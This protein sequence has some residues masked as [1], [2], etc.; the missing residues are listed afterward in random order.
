MQCICCFNYY[1]KW[2]RE[3]STF[4]HESSFHTFT[5]V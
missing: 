5:S 3:M 4:R 1:Q 2:Q